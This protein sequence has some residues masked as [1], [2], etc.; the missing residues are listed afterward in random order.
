MTLNKLILFTVGIPGLLLMMLWPVFGFL[1]FWGTTITLAITVG[2]AFYF[3]RFG[4]T[5]LRLFITENP[6]LRGI[7]IASFLTALYATLLWAGYSLGAE[8]LRVALGIETRHA[9]VLITV[10]GLPAIPALWHLYSA[11]GIPGDV[12]KI[13]RGTRTLMVLTL[14]FFAWWYHIQ[15]NQFFNHTTGKTNFWVAD[16]EGKAYYSPGFSPVTGERLREGTPEDAERF[17]EASWVDGAQRWINRPSSKE[18]P[19]P[20]LF[21]DNPCSGV[22]AG[23]LAVSIQNQGHSKPVEYPPG[24]ECNLYSGDDDIMIQNAL[25][26]S[27]PRKW[28]KSVTIRGDIKLLTRIVRFSGPNGATVFLTECADGLG[29][30]QTPRFIS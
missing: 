23:C 30:I 7:F 5:N 27:L 25:T 1:G 29:N 20:V 3:W 21:T 24:V 15:P 17:K 28:S 12:E 14:A 22:K 16:A 2:V 18:T 9:W 8:K 11:T 4:A 6:L 26:S 19:R 13:N 10:L